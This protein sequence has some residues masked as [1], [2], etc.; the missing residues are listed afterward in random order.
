MFRRRALVAIV[1]AS[2]AASMTFWPDDSPAHAAGVVWIQPPPGG[3]DATQ[4]I[5]NAVK[6]APDGTTFR[7]AANAK[8]RIDGTVKITNRHNLTFDGNGATFYAGT[9]GDK[10][11][12]HWWF[13]GGSNI[14]V[15]DL[16][17]RG[18]NR[19]PGVDG[20]WRSDR[21]HQHGFTFR[22]VTGVTLRDVRVTDVYGDALLLGGARDGSSAWTT[23]VRVSGYHFE[24][25]GRQGVAIIGARNVVLENGYVGD[26]YRNLYQ[27]EGNKTGDGYRDVVIRSNRLGMAGMFFVNVAMH[28]GVTADGIMV[29]GNRGRGMDIAARFG[30]GTRNIRFLEN[31]SDVDSRLEHANGTD[32][33]S[34]VRLIKVQGAEVRRNRQPLPSALPPS[35]FVYERQSTE[36]TVTGNTHP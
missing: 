2:L 12:K 30:P 31:T 26:V 4:R 10:L 25:T 22:G 18:A 6:N 17:V 29:Q 19:R 1:L 5:V 35:K 8:Y 9:D 21:E 32:Y 14:T 15:H 16:A 7:F 24:R 13:Q 36:V 3:G 34:V 28:S 11:R 33:K 20:T 27:L 23:N